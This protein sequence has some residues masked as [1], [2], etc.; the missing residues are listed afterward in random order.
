MVARL[1][2]AADWLVNAA[3]AQGLD[4]AGAEHVVDTSA[5]RHIQKNHGK[6]AVETARGQ[7]AVTPQDL[8]RIPELVGDPDRVIFGTAN[9]L[10]RPQI[11]Y[12]KTLEDGSMLYLE[13]VRAKRNQLA[14]VSLRKYP[15]TTNVDAITSTLRPNVRS[16]GGAEP[17]IADRPVDSKPPRGPTGPN[18]RTGPPSNG[19]GR[20]P[21][22]GASADH[23]IQSDPQLKAL[24]DATAQFAAEHGVTD[25]AESQEG[26]SPDDLVKGMRAAAQCLIDAADEV[27]E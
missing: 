15:A 2:Q 1:G 19:D 20:T 24:A 25:A 26:R 4:I 9:R 16:D 22:G 3:K 11:G 17:E 18:A 10:G 21:G 14:A 23:L 7:V 13:E 5:V 27:M 6:A 8:A 12:V